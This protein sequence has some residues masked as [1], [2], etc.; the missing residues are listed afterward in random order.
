[1]RLFHRKPKP[2]PKEILRRTEIT[3]ERE[4]LSLELRTNPAPPTETEPKQPKSS[5]TKD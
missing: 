1:M 5:R 2:E 3:I 4:W